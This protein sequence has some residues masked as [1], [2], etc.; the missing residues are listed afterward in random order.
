VVAEHEAEHGGAGAF[1]ADQEV[2]AWDHRV[3]ARGGCEAKGEQPG[4][5][6]N[7]PWALE[8][9]SVCEQLLGNWQR[10]DR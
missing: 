1:G 2:W 5:T 8:Y 4:P 7:E 3:F 9:Y 6:A 10:G